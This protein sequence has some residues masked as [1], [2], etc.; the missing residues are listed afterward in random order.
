MRDSRAEQLLER[1][2]LGPSGPSVGDA[3][4]QPGADAGSDIPTGTVL[5]H[6][7]QLTD[8]SQGKA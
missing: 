7:G 3:T 4:E 6:F 2:Q 8:L 1:D 5:P